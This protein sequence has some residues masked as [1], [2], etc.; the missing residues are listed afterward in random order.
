MS[1]ELFKNV[2]KHVCKSYIF[3]MYVLRGFGIKQPTMVDMP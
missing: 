2:I 3:N 1:L